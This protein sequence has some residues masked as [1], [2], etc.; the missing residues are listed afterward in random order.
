MIQCPSCGEN[1]KFDIASQM[2][3]CEA[4]HNQYDPYSFDSKTS[5]G[6]EGK[7]FDENDYEVT[8]FTCPQCGGE[9]LS[10]DNAAAGFCSFCGA[11]TILYTRISK[12]HRPNYIIPFKKTKEDCKRAYSSMMKKAIFAPKELK[13]PAKIDSFRGIYMPYWAFYMTQKGHVSL[14]GTKSH[15]KGDYIYTDHFNL[16][17]DL[18]AYY[19]GLSY[20]ASS[21]FADSISQAIAPYDV[22]GMKA[23]TPA[24]LSGFYADTPDVGS[25]AYQPEAEQFAYDESIKKIRQTFSGYTI[26][27]STTPSSLHTK[28]ENVDQAMFPVWFMS[29][30]NKD[31][32]AY[33]TVNGQ[34]GKVVSDLPVDIKK[35]MLGSLLLAIPIFLLLCLSFTATPRVLLTLCALIAVVASVISTVELGRIVR[36]EGNLD[37]K[38]VM[39]VSDHQ[40]LAEANAKTLKA[41]KAK[42]V[43]TPGWIIGLGVYFVIAF[44]CILV[45]LLSGASSSGSGLGIIWLVILV[46]SI[47]VSIIGMNKVNKVPGKKGLVGLI[48]A[49]VGIG[50][51]VTVMLINPASDFI[52]YGVTIITLVAEFFTL[53]DVM[54]EY[55]I[56]STRRLPQFDKQGGDDRA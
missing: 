14:K 19:K 22:K 46:A 47:V 5:D 54:E 8:V 28:V 20:D 34:T 13:D 37:D 29:Y 16:H 48:T 39:A 15:R 55:N 3:A 23:F 1:L 11:S 50:L 27:S 18:D 21:S 6:I 4:C 31:R 40:K 45:P 41:S 25:F 33:A 32:V 10:T 35:Y 42:K 17:G 36:Q 51:G 38:G 9:I 43:K 52:Y 26:D 56:L 2:M 12:E 24:Y 53:K 30:R 44:L 7:D 49:L